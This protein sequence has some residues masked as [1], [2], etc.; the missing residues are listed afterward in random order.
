M[1]DFVKCIIKR[2]AVGIR[3]VIGLVWYNNAAAAR[4]TF[5]WNEAHDSPRKTFTMQDETHNAP[6]SPCDA[7]ATFIRGALLLQEKWVL[8]IVHSLLS[9]PTG[10]SELVRRGGINTTTLTQRLTLLE[11]A[12]LLVK[13]IHSTM[14]PRTSYDLTEAGRALEPILD[15]ITA[16]SRK[17]LPAAA[18][19]D[20]C[21]SEPACPEVRAALV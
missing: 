1:L 17:H 16:W 3:A 13:T 12:G 5:P 11:Q 15:S 2:R 6:A 19:A 4:D 14:P 7:A 20:P 21:P 10:F 9:G 18:A 8:M